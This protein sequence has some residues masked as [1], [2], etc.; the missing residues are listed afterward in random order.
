MI[1]DYSEKY[2]VSLLAG[3]RDRARVRDLMGG[4][5][6]V[7]PKTEFSEN[8]IDVFGGIIARAWYDA[9]D[10][11][12]G[13]EFYALGSEFYFSGGQ[14]LG[15]DFQCIEKLLSTLGVAFDVEEDGTGISINAGRLRFYIPDMLE[16]GA[17]AEI[18][19][20]YVDLEKCK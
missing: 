11:L 10:I 18:K 16:S 13:I 19:S 17:L 14:V 7:L 5:F 3:V 12:I 1:F 2:G 4:D 6:R 20:V 15:K 9:S 8:T